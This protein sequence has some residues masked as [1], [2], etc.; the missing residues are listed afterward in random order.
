MFLSHFSAL[1]LLCSLGPV[2][3]SPVPE[4]LSQRDVAIATGNA[5]AVVLTPQ[6][7]DNHPSCHGVSRHYVYFIESSNPNITFFIDTPWYVRYH[8][9]LKKA[10]VKG[11]FN[12]TSPHTAHCNWIV[13]DHVVKAAV[14]RGDIGFKETE[15]LDATTYYQPSEETV[16]RIRNILQNTYPA[17]EIAMVVI[18]CTS[19]LW[20][21]VLL[22]LASAWGS[23]IKEWYD[24]PRPI[25][26]PKA[27][28]IPRPSA[29]LTV[30]EQTFNFDTRSV[31][32]F[33]NS[34]TSSVFDSE[35]G[36]FVARE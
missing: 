13:V 23:S 14:E 26:A 19:P 22:I 12:I 4:E 34:S 2:T 24:R 10:L 9:D 16:L 35:K 28:K 5:S 25:K 6:D 29:N 27:P 32:S 15:G 8:K 31:G 3:P 18:F 21:P 33:T 20:L 17:V 1:L 11:G 7:S 36:Y 30:P